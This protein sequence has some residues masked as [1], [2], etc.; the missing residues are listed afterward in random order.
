MGG[1]GVAFQFLIGV[2]QF[3]P[4]PGQC[5]L[6]LVQQSSERT[7]VDGEEEIAL[8]HLI[9]FLEMDALHY[10]HNLGLDGHRRE[11]FDGADGTDLNRDGLDFTCADG[12]RYRFFLGAASAF[13]FASGII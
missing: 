2:G 11:G 7:G 8:F 13:F 4:V 12:H 10:P 1:L 5:P 3:G 9:A 6:R